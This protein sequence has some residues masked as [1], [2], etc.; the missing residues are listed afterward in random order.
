MEE[1]N[2]KESTPVIWIGFRMYYSALGGVV[3]KNGALG[4]LISGY[5]SHQYA[6]DTVLLGSATGMFGI[7]LINKC[8]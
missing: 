4:L 6:F 5:F 7:I 2:Q 1:Y 3:F 8:M